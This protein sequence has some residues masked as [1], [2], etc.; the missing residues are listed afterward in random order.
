MA[1]I[2][3]ILGWTSDDKV[4][5]DYRQTV[6]GS[7]R[8]SVGSFPVKLLVTG[9]KLSTGSMTADQDIEPIIS[10]DDAADKL[11]AGSTAYLQCKAALNVP[12]VN[13]YAAPPAEASGAV[14]GACT[15]TFGGTWTE[16][17]TVKFWLDNEYVEVSVGATEDSTAAGGR[18]REQFGSLDDGPAA[19]SGSTTACILTS[20]SLGTQG[21]AH[22]LYYDMSE[23]PTG[24]TVTVTSGTAL[25]PRLYPFA[26]GTGTESLAN[27]IALLKSDT[28]D[29]IA[30]AQTDATNAALVEAHMS[31]EAVSTIKHLEHAIFGATSTLVA[32]TSLAQTTLNDYRSAVVWSENCET[33]PACIAA[34]AAAVRSVIEP[35]NPNYNFDDTPL[36]G[37]AVQRFKADKPLHASLKSALNAGV[38]PLIDKNGAACVARGIV[39]HCLNGS[40]PDYRCLDWGDA[41]VPDYV[42]K[43]LGAAWTSFK[44]AN[45]Y[46][47][48]DPAG[49]E[50]EPPEGVGT[51]SRWNAVVYAILKDDETRNL[52]QDVDDNLPQTQYDADRSALV[53]AVPCVVRKQQHA[54]GISVRQQAA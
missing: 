24:L 18:A 11:G 6:Y 34:T 22:K 28:Y 40:V 39:T 45:P 32:A 50:P 14:G 8:I 30:V 26:G 17:G 23:A 36:P 44:E 33:H 21:N 38:T 5:G 9:T 54:I 4:P 41:I 16:S 52:V 10:L 20:R 53:S 43:Q 13:I 7:G 2:M 15:I 12:G 42:S 37:V 49:S 46:V 1:S 25:H 27:V 31:S 35:T 48:P 3:P 47:G 51:P 19:V 29:Y